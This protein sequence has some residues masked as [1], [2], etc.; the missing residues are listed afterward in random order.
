MPRLV[1]ALALAVSTH[2]ATLELPVSF[3]QNRGQWSAAPREAFRARTGTHTVELARGA[4]RFLSNSG[5]V[6]QFVP[7]NQGRLAAPIAQEQLIG[8]S[9][10][11][12]AGRNIT[13]VPHFGRIV[14][15]DVWP[16][17]DLAFRIDAN[18]VEFDWEIAA[19]ADASRILMQFPGAE[20]LKVDGEGNLDLGPLRLRKPEA[21]QDATVGAAFVVEPNRGVRFRL[22]EYDPAKP[23]VIDP[24]VEASYF[25]GGPTS[26]AGI[27]DVTSD[28]SGNIYLT[29]SV[30]V[31]SPDTFPVTA[32][33]YRAVANFSVEVYV[34]KLAPDAR[35]VVYCTY[36]GAG[37]PLD[38]FGIRVDG[39]GNAI[40]AGNTGSTTFPVTANAFVARRSSSFSVAN[41]DAFV[42][43]L[44]TNGSQ[45]LF[46][47]Y[48]GGL[49]HESVFALS[50]DPL[51][52]IYLAG[53]TNSTDFPT[54]TG[55]YRTSVTIPT[56][57]SAGF[58]AK[59]SSSGSTL[60]YSTFFDEGLNMIAAE[61]A[62]TVIVAGP[63]SKQAFPVTSGAYRTTYSNGET[64]I[65]RLNPSGTAISASTF[66]GGSS[67]EDLTSLRIDSSGSIYV[68]GVTNS[69]DFPATT[70]LL[71]GM[72]APG[73]AFLTKLNPSLTQVVFS[74]LIGGG[75]FDKFT[76]IDLDP[77]GAIHAIGFTTSVDFP[78]L[79]KGAQSDR[80]TGEFSPVGVRFAAT[81][82]PLD[83]FHYSGTKRASVAQAVADTQF[84]RVTAPSAGV[85]VVIGQFVGTNFP[86][87][88][89]AAAADL[90]H[91]FRGFLAKFDYDS[92]CSFTVSPTTLSFP[93]SGG[94]ATLAIA[95]PPSCRFVARASQD[96]IETDLL[97]A[98]TVR[99]RVTG[100]PG[101][102]LGG[103]VF[104]AGRK[105]P[106]RTGNGCAYAADPGIIH[107]PAAG[108]RYSINPVTFDDCPWSPV[109]SHVWISDLSGVAS[110][111]TGVSPIQ[112]K[113]QPN[114]GLLPREATVGIST[115]SG[116]V[117]RQAGTQCTFQ[118]TPSSVTISDAPQNVVFQVATQQG[119]EWEA[120][121]LHPHVAPS[122]SRR[123]GSGTA[124][125]AVAANL[126]SSQFAT[127]TVAGQAVFIYRYDRAYG[128][129]GSVQLLS[130]GGQAV[131]AGAVFA[132]TI[133]VR[134]VGAN[135]LP[136]TNVAVGLQAPLI[137]ASL[138]NPAARTVA[139]GDG[140]ATFAVAANATPGKY[141]VQITFPLSENPLF[142]PMENLGPPALV[143][144]PS[145]AQFAATSATVAWTRAAGDLDYRISILN[146]ANNSYIVNNAMTVDAAYSVAG[147]PCTSA[148]LRISI[149][150]RTAGGTLSPPNDFPVAAPS[151][152]NAETRGAIAAPA[153]GSVLTS[154]TPTFSWAATTGALDYWLDIGDAVGQGNFFGGVVS[155]TSRQSPVLECNG[156]PLYIRLWARTAAGYQPPV[157]VTFLRSA[158]CSAPVRAKLTHPAPNSVLRF[159]SN[160]FQWQEGQQA[161]D[162]WLDVGTALG[163]GNLS[164]GV[165]T[166]ASTRVVLPSCTGQTIYVRLWTRTA[167]GYMPPVDTTLS[168]PI[169]CP[170]LPILHQ[171]MDPLPDSF[172]STG[173]SNV[174]TVPA[175]RGSTAITLRFGSSPG[176]SD[177]GTTPVN[178]NSARVQPVA[179]P[180]FNCPADSYYYLRSEWVSAQGSEFLDYRMLC[181]QSPSN[182][183][184]SPAPQTQLSG[185][186]QEFS[187][188]VP[189]AV[190][191]AWLD[192]GTSLG[193]GDISAGF[194]AT[195]SKPI[196]GL[197]CNGQTL[198]VRWWPRLLNLEYGAPFD[199]TLAAGTYCPGLTRAALAH[200]LIGARMSSPTQTFNWHAVERA[201]GYWLDVGT[202]LGLGNV[203]GGPVST[204]FATVSNI[205][206][207]GN[208]VFV[209]LWTRVAGA[210]LSPVDYRFQCQSAPSVAL[211]T[212]PAVTGATAF[213]VSG[214]LGRSATFEW[215]PGNGAQD[216]WLDVGTAK[217]SGDITS[218]VVTGLKKHVGG[219]P[220]NTPVVWVRLWTRIN[221]VWQTPVDYQFSGPR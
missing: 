2:A 109:I 44:N 11:L 69:S 103:Y 210:W 57:T 188:A 138:A 180:K 158:N 59:V 183:Q 192:V 12:G 125:F 221:G 40:I 97:N 25:V 130:G 141:F 84:T 159:Q 215:S 177:F 45:L 22:G 34:M 129:G 5:S 147:L 156:E 134:L 139:G 166:A 10:Y 72:T 73:N 114:V 64:Y 14:Y 50:L 152:C 35:T 21:R 102:S 199:Y 33:A 184:F 36:V 112:L 127:A 4:I 213:P 81:G 43:K 54:T 39:A 65:T 202:A 163:Q 203:F 197:P 169:T 107:V 1:L 60:I 30:I 151:N 121:S 105:I 119:C 132:R 90:P 100:T 186:T 55:A 37:G 189:F 171:L 120:S 214:P 3:E 217:G 93:V 86:Q 15:K 178:V 13:G 27:R 80:S 71:N 153:P 208:T 150:A 168:A 113:V 185:E 154:A 204:D 99:V 128:N 83:S 58:V 124:A 194:T 155:G 116:V 82:E 26:G 164:G 133:R 143:Y 193:Q 201:E 145:G 9:N 8:K 123:I 91:E 108:G 209:R 218:G 85:A 212:A 67:G 24:V 94:E 176:G 219:I 216:Y 137:G 51:G 42:A 29:G 148:P 56:Q 173:P 75:G 160:V 195:G 131:R 207:S 191:G 76:H 101:I 205:P 117:I 46:A 161:L 63:T 96:W 165:V 190:S 98:T 135:G 87:T 20:R 62:G 68:A 66:L 172:Q 6:V 77:T 95:G 92:P 115:E 118:V 23:L 78:V 196:G 162:Y 74:T 198:Y 110:P 146:T 122:S 136:M 182:S 88:F 70:S 32:G 206:C 104:V 17:I 140:I 52:D 187:W 149:A 167:A 126:N 53:S 142:L 31:R 181:A 157:D 174:F 179:V 41:R 28:A 38:A 200:P 175:T 79:P 89:P 7:G 19:H 106:V 170:Q 111:R 220:A 49:L 16:G 211:L 47:T 18:R 48:F 144:P 61:P